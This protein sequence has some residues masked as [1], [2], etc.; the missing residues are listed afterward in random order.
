LKQ[1]RGVDCYTG[2]DASVKNFLTS[3]P[4]VADLRS[5]DMR[6]RHWAMLMEVCGNVS[7]CFQYTTLYK[8]SV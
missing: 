1:I 8:Y 7:I 2:T 3:I 5:P 4:L 6:E